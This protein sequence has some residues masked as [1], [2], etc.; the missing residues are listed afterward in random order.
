MLKMT[1]VVPDG[2][3]HEVEAEDGNTVLEVA[4]RHGFDLEGACE[5]C[6]A[7]STCHVIVDDAWFAK[8]SDASEEEE[9]MLDL[10]FDVRPTSRL[11]WNARSPPPINTPSVTRAMMP[12]KSSI[13]ACAQPGYPRRPGSPIW[14][15]V[16]RPDPPPCAAP[17]SAPAMG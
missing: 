3:R 4:H 14:I 2:T 13:S 7:C 17:I 5:G 11:G 1:F 9:D 10:A 15:P 12:S 6:M 16:K 8:L